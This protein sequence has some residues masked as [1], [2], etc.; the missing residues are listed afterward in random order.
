MTAKAR[1]TC[2]RLTADQRDALEEI[3]ALT[4]KTISDLIRDAVLRD[5]AAFRAGRAV[6]VTAMLGVLAPPMEGKSVEPEQ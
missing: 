6:Y 4:G 2:V 3:G 5:I 1:P